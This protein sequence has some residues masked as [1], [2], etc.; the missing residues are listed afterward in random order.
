MDYKDMSN[1]EIKLSMERLTNNFEMKK[2]K[3]VELCKEMEEIEREFLS[4]KKELELRKNI[5]I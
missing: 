5:F 2:N 3:L 4:A 1:A